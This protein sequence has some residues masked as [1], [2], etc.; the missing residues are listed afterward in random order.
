MSNYLFISSK[1]II[2]RIPFF[3]IPAGH[4]SPAFS[5]HPPASS[6]HLSQLRHLVM[7][8][9]S[10]CSSN[11]GTT[12]ATLPAPRSPHQT[13]VSMW[14]GLSHGQ[15]PMMQHL[16]SSPQATAAPAAARGSVFVNFFSVRCLFVQFLGQISFV[17]ILCWEINKVF[18]IWI[19]VC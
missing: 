12:A 5:L 7:R 9:G 3:F 18:Y 16:P 8:T 1:C 13:P 14:L 19:K 10:P 17:Y 4:P 11:L 2:F 15:Q 6:H